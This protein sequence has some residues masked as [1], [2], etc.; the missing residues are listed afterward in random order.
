VTKNAVT[1]VCTVCSNKVTTL[2][3]LSE[4]PVCNNNH[5]RGGRVMK[6]VQETNSEEQNNE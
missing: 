4:P 1:W 6:K 2:V 3:T 5:L